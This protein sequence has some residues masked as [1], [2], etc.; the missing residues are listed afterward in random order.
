MSKVP[1]VLLIHGL[2]SSPSE[3]M[4]V[5]SALRRAGYRVETLEIPGYTYAAGIQ[6]RPWR[7]WLQAALTAFD[8]LRSE[9][10]SVSVGG[11]CIGG[12]LALAVAAHRPGKVRALSVLSPTVFFDGWGLPWLT[13]LRHIGYYTP[14][15]YFWRVPEQ[16]PYGVKNPLIRRWIAREMAQR[17]VSAAGAAYLPLAG[18]HES[19]RLIAFVKRAIA[20]IATPTL[21]IHAREDEISTLRSPYYLLERLGSRVKQLRVLEDSYHMVT[22]DNER[23][24]VVDAISDFFLE[25]APLPRATV[26]PFPPRV[27]VA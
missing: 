18:L 21:I 17:K 7:D 25:Q 27:Q 10:D 6:V 8:K 22:L 16:E 9:H 20:E 23:Q 3:M 11:L 1:A 14:F 24:Q 4:P 19:E 26:L 13:R 15:R 5:T 2:W 12:M